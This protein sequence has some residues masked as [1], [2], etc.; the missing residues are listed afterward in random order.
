VLVPATRGRAD[1]DSTIAELR[2][3]RAKHPLKGLRTKDLIEE[4]RRF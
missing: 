4:G 2:A 1:L 3:L